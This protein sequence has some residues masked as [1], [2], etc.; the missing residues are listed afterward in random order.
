VRVVPHPA[1]TQHRATVHGYEAQNPILF[2]VQYGNNTMAIA[3]QH[4][5]AMSAMK[6]ELSCL[7]G[8][9]Q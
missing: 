9:S 8:G 5:M 7:M 4:Q 1:K 3:R 6:L 2:S